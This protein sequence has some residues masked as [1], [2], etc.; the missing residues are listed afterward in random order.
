[1]NNPLVGDIYKL[2]GT[3][4]AVMNTEISLEEAIGTLVRQP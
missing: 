4:T 2:Q 1:M 3:A